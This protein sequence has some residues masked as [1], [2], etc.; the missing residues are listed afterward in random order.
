MIAVLIASMLAIT[1]A[2]MN[3]K[4]MIATVIA[5]MIARPCILGSSLTL[6]PCSRY[7]VHASGVLQMNPIELG[8]SDGSGGDNFVEGISPTWLEHLKRCPGMEQY[9]SRYRKDQTLRKNS[10]SKVL[11]VKCTSDSGAPLACKCYERKDERALERWAL[12]VI[13]H[14]SVSGHPNIVQFHEV[15][16]SE[17][18]FA[19][20]ARCNLIMELCRESLWDFMSF[21]QQVQ[22]TDIEFFGKE[23]CMGLRHI[24]SFSILHRDIKPAN[25]LLRHVGGQRM[26]LKIC[27]FG[28]SVFLTRVGEKRFPSYQKLAPL[29][30]TY[31]YSSPEVAKRTPYAF[32]SDMWSVGVILYELLQ[33]DARIPAVE[34]DQATE[35][36]QNLEAAL[37]RFCNTVDRRR[38]EQVPIVSMEKLAMQ[39]LE[40]A[41][42]ARPSAERAVEQ[43]ASM[44]LRDAEAEGASMGLRDA[45]ADGAR[46]RGVV[47]EIPDSPPDAL[48]KQEENE[49]T[50]EGAIG[51]A[52]ASMDLRDAE[53]FQW[54]DH[55]LL[56]WCVKFRDYLDIPGDVSTF[57]AAAE[58]LGRHR[59]HV[60]LMYILARVKYPT[61]VRDLAARFAT[62]PVKFRACNLKKACHDC[63][64]H[65]ASI[66]ETKALQRE[67]IIYDDQRMGCHMGLARMMEKLG[68]LRA[69]V[70]GME[71]S[72]K[73]SLGHGSPRKTYV[74]AY[75]QQLLQT[76]MDDFEQVYVVV[77][78]DLTNDSLF[79][80]AD[81]LHSMFSNGFGD[82]FVELPTVFKKPA[83]AVE[84]P[85]V[86]KK[87]ASNL[88]RP[89]LTSGGT[90]KKQPYNI[91][92]YMRKHLYWLV[93]QHEAAQTCHVDWSIVKLGDM[94]RL[95][96]D[97]TGQL[98]EI[99]FDTYV[100]PVAQC[101][102]V[103]PLLVSC[104]LCLTRRVVTVA[105]KFA[106]LSDDGNR[107]RLLQLKQDHVA[108]YG[109]PASPWQLV[110]DF[111]QAA[112]QKAPSASGGS[113]ERL[114]IPVASPPPAAAAPPPPAPIKAEAPPPPVP[115]PSGEGNAKR[116]RADG[117]GCRPA[118]T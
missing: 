68:L 14:K 80:Q 90:D 52:A 69:S 3:A 70:K 88:S 101:L 19:T 55:E 34:F 109:I 108:A 1:I 97:E 112:K 115:S 10:S 53:K 40:V 17:L 27:D 23:M 96:P 81:K 31:R 111:E 59:G 38:Q 6:R 20:S 22:L 21:W 113:H 16:Y 39:L 75:D 45:N 63:I 87:P 54:K 98:E 103:H 86:F 67:M 43:L 89:S 94:A 35:G 82:K 44:G 37:L 25:C 78:G 72:S 84:L 95:V 7:L 42:E 11:V 30:T 9:K 24:H 85:K 28:N 79:Q 117:E 26:V 5:I 74:L 32:P 83:S 36:V 60:F 106:I 51:A 12:E 50:G 18:S 4:I 105:E 62:L 13:I 58:T 110:K 118:G 66:N 102:G 33:D 48:C 114:A 41:P 73:I 46:G 2:T 93:M 99:G 29:M 104:H 61:V 47:V 92:H 107:D 100:T 116:L 64:C 76:M 57:V 77:D 71:N 65:A 8:G 49:I 91:L 15:Y 56:C